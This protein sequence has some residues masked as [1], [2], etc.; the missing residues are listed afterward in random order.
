MKTTAAAP[1][2]QFEYHTKPAGWN[3]APCPICG[4]PTKRLK[5]QHRALT[6]DESWAM[7]ALWIKRVK[8]C[9][10]TDSNE[11]SLGMNGEA[12]L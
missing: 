12:R 1:A 5:A 10:G 4:C 11:V 6:A 9:F 8:V 3:G 2:S 7:R